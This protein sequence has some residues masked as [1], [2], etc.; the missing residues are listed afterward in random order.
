MK[1]IWR[2]ILGFEGFYQISNFGRIKSLSRM[3][4]TKN[5][6]LRR[7]KERIIATKMGSGKSHTV[8][9]VSLRSKELGQNATFSV[10]SLVK[11]YFPDLGQ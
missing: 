11:K 6:S 9:L 3:S 1:E 8:L 2:D 4:P 7:L 5:G 10:K